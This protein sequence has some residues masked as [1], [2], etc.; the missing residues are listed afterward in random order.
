MPV[1]CYVVF[2][3]VWWIVKDRLGI[4]ALGIVALGI[5]YLY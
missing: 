2:T 5:P 1:V 4:V 3:L